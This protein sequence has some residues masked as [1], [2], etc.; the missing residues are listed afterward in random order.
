MK[1]TASQFLYFYN[2][3]IKAA[4]FTGLLFIESIDL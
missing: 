4:R 1:N 2:K 3:E